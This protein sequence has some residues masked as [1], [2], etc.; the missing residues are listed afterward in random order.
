MVS[1]NFTETPNTTAKVINTI[2]LTNNEFLSFPT[3]F[4]EQ[5]RIREMGDEIGLKLFYDKENMAIA[6]QFVSGDSPGLYKLNMSDKYGATS[7][8]RAFLLNNS[9]DIKKYAGKHEYKKYSASTLGLDGSD[10]FVI[11]LDNGGRTM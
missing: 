4:L 1:F 7:K 2:T 9:L 8:V 6:M 5:Y 3:F 10:V 11:E